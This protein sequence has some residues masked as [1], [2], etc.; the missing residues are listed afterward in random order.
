MGHDKIKFIKYLGPIK[1]ENNKFT[2]S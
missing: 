2:N 1:M